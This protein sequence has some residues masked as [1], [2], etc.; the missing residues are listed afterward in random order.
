[1]LNKY[2]AALFDMDGTLIDYK[3]VIELAWAT[4]ATKYGI[5]INQYDLELHVH[6]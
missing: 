1:M 6:G 4:V 2:K 5:N 3:P